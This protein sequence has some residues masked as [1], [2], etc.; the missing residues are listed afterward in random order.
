MQQPSAEAA[1]R[2]QGGHLV[3]VDSPE[4][5]TLLSD[6]C[7]GEQS[8]PA[9]PVLPR[10]TLLWTGLHAVKPAGARETDKWQTSRDNWYGGC[11]VLS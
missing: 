8:R 2:K 10:L 3:T 4:I 6:K 11:G 1:C 9:F 7:N 5:S